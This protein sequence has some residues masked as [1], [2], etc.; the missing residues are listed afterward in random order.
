MFAN[1]ILS[2]QETGLV[3]NSTTARLIAYKRQ[4]VKE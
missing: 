4:I 1:C 2:S 3:I